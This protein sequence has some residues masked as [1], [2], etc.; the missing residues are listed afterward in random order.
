MSVIGIDVSHHQ[1]PIAWRGVAR[2]GIGFAF[3]KATEGVLTRDPR[4]GVN[5]NA[6]GDAGLLRGAYHFF[7]PAKPVRAQV[8]HFCSVTGA[9]SPGELPPVLDIE[10][11]IPYDEWP[12]VP[13]RQRLELALEWLRAVEA[14]MGVRP[15]VYTR[16]GF[17]AAMFGAPGPLAAFPLW[18]AH[19]TLQPAPACPDGWTWTFWQYTQSGRVPGISGAVDMNRFSGSLAELQSLGADIAQAA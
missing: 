1:G 9:F 2:G 12:T 13:R 18:I 15:I 4:F 7:H 14:R 6:A 10:E 16:K 11:T 8:D 5:W 3:I 19:Y 17:V